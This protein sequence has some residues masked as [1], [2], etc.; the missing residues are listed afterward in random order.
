MRWFILLLVLLAS[1]VYAQDDA[2]CQGVGGQC[3]NSCDVNEIELELTVPC[4]NGICCVSN[5]QSLNRMNTGTTCSDGTP[6]GACSDF[7]SGGLGKPRYCENGQLI[8]SCETCGCPEGSFCSQ[9]GCLSAGGGTQSSD[10]SLVNSPP[11]ISQIPSLNAPFDSMD[12]NQYAEDPEGKDLI[13]T[14]NNG[15]STY[16]S[17]IVQC[18]IANDLFSCFPRIEGTEVITILASDGEKTSSMVFSLG[19]MQTQSDTQTNAYPRANAGSDKTVLI[20]QD[21][22]LDGS[23]SYDPDGNLPSLSSAFVWKE[24]ANVLGQGK[25]TKTKFPK[26]GVYTVTLE[27]TDVKGAVSKDTVNIRVNKKEKCGGTSTIYA[28]QDTICTKKWPS[29]EGELLA[30]NSRSNSCDLFE[31][32]DEDLD[33]IIEDAISCCDGTPLLDRKRSGSCSFANVNSGNDVKTC[34]ALY[35]I[36]SIGDGAVYMQDYF[37]SE[38]CCYGVSEL[39]PEQYQLYTRGPLPITDT[40]LS[41][42]QCK[43]TAENRV[44]GEWLSDTRLDKNNIALQ[45]VHAGA[46]INILSTGTCVDYSAAVVT[47]LRKLGFRSSDIYLAEATNHAYT[48][49]KFPIDRKYTIIDTTGNADPITLGGLP[50]QDYP[51]CENI[52]NC[53]N[54]NG[55]ALCPEMSKIKGC[56][57]VEESVIKQGSRVT[58]KTKKVIA[59]IIEKLTFE[60][61]R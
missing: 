16:N 28:P 48:L 19:V 51:Y 53:Y 45:D 6:Y 43:T 2:S 8:Y 9:G 10:L 40:D 61:K 30:I 20:N 25:I 60:A 17:E 1:S 15:L 18:D 21:V 54:D 29:K 58:F 26:P 12:L 59:T 39:C 57:R 34:Q 35:I 14:F 24:G 23:K 4:D 11:T 5:V 56:E 7:N 47:L 49:V 41:L 38:M 37:Y 27:V 33:Y 32:C 22:V 31:V 42:L 50:P 3:K 52:V 55:K 36:K 44:L 46:T 13:F